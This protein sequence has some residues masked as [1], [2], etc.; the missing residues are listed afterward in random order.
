M[1]PPE[2]ENGGSRATGNRRNETDADQ[3]Q[4]LRATVQ[5]H[6][7]KRNLYPR[8]LPIVL[9]A[10]AYPPAW[11][12]VTTLVVLDQPCDCG[13]WH[14]HKVR[15]DAPA[16]LPRK[17]RCGTKYELALHP[18]RARRNRRAA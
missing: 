4:A 1:K 6:T 7:D 5:P 18:P 8:Q 13:D 16:L 10:T 3:T 17:A 15:G 11:G 12:T 9:S 2:N 14:N